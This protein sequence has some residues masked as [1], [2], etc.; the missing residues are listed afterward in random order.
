MEDKLK[1]LKQNLQNLSSVV[2]AFSGGVDSTFL[3]KTCLEI[4]KKQQVL[5][6]TASSEIFP[7][8]ELD[9]AKKIAADLDVSHMIIEVS[10]LDI[11]EFSANTP[12]RCYICKKNIFSRL[13]SVAVERG[14]SCV[15]EGTNYDDLNDFRPGL[16]A[17]KELGVKS[18][19][20]EAGLTKSEIRQ[21]SKKIGLYTWDKPSLACL[22]SRFPYGEAITKQKIKMVQRAEQVLKDSGFPQ[23]RVR[24]HGDIARIEI[25]PAQFN[26]FSNEQLRKLVTSELKHIGYTYVTLDLMGYR[27]GSMN[28]LLKKERTELAKN[29]RDS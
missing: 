5:A 24:H 17:I 21:A 28:E 8:W 25:D 19:L 1:Q 16:R 2:L 13:K 22:S 18:P 15:I 26:M 11:P 9:E 7:R 14:F 12:D 3:L 23:Y 29:K 27:T 4:L 20:K 6:V 10:T